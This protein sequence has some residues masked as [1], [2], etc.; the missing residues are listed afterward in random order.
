LLNVTVR[1]VLPDSDSFL[2]CARQ[3]VFSFVLLS[4]RVRSADADRAVQALTR[5]LIEIALE[6]GGTHYLPYRLHATRE[7]FRRAHPMAAMK[8]HHDPS[9]D[10]ASFGILTLEA[11]F[12][13]LRLDA[14]I[15]AGDWSRDQ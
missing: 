8:R 5:E 10:F 11:V 3:E 2:R 13:G 7:Q 9:S 4:C 12:T 6:H 14:K 1:N 15:R